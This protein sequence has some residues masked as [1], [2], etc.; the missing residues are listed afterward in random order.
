MSARALH[1]G[2]ALAL[3]AMLAA[4]GFR[5]LY[6]RIGADPGAQRIFASIYVLP[7]DNA[8]ESTAYELRNELIDLLE[9]RAA[10]QDALYRLDVELK[11]RRESSAEQN[12]VV[13]GVHET[14]ITRYNYSLVADY[15]LLDAKGAVVTKGTAST[16]TA[17]NVVTSPYATMI[18]QQDAQ[19]QAAEDIATRIRL[20]LGVFFANGARKSP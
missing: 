14:D 16:L 3:C 11:E 9:A 2:L 12:Q 19:K 10:P 6:G 13:A 7:I 20:D 1:L 8:N 17:Y 15:K 18:G 4:C 5:P